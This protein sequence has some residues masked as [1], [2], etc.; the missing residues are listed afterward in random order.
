MG[1]LQMADLSCLRSGIDK[2]FI[3]FKWKQLQK[4]KNYLCLASEINFPICR[5]DYTS[6]L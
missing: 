2:Y 6:K 3:S 5:N 4:Q 1:F